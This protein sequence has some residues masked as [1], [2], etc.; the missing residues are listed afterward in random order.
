[1]SKGKTGLMNGLEKFNQ[2]E[3][4]EKIF[5][6]AMKPLL[7]QEQNSLA[8]SAINPFKLKNAISVG[9]P[10]TPGPS[11]SCHPASSLLSSALSP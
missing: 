7:N 1:M 11:V 8:S 3:K 4:A 6:K 10:K 9:K 2:T 5:G